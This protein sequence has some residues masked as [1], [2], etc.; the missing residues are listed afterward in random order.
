MAIL[1]NSVVFT[2][3]GITFMQ[4]G[5]EV[6]RTKGGNSNSYNASYQTNEI[7]YSLKI[8]N[9]DIFKIYQKLISLKQNTNLF[10]LDFE[11]ASNINITV[12]TD[13]STI[14]YTL[15]DIENNKEYKII[16][17]NGSVSNHTINLEGYTLYLDTLGSEIELTAQTVI[18]PYQTI[19]AVK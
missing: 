3:Q 7:N 13:N 11:K 2:S 8:K 5:E 4:S 18:N 6:L 15:V 19:I 16:H 12:S 17:A 9:I 14:E 1:A 10:G